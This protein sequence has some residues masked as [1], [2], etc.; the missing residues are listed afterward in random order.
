MTESSVPH[1]R[2]HLVRALRV[3]VSLFFLVLPATALH[4][5]DMQM[6]DGVSPAS[7]LPFRLCRGYAIVAKAWIGTRHVNVLLD[8]GANP[9]IVDD[10]VEVVATAQDRHELA[11]LQLGPM[12]KRDLRVNVHDLEFVKQYIGVPVEAIVGMDVLATTNFTID[13]E[14]RKI[15]FNDTLA[16]G[17]SVPLE[18]GPP[19]VTVAVTIGAQK[20][21]MLLGSGASGLMLFKSRAGSDRL[22]GVRL[23][24]SAMGR[25]LERL[26]SVDQLFLQD[27]Q[28]GP[29]KLDFKTATI[30]EDWPEWD[31]TFDGLIGV[32][33]LK[34]KRVTFDFQAG[35]FRWV[36]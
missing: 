13:Y 20:L 10:G 36:P 5:A 18:S 9:T 19:L 22:P 24:D 23:L 4:A 32:S 25:N 29:A 33:A 30:A 27:V 16:D 21:S 15:L 12:T 34:F 26:F 8:T 28:M 3:F 35:L 2:G 1:H 7:A 14:H 31:S 17:F 11:L 6:R